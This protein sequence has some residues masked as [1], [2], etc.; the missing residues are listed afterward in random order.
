MQT[1]YTKLFATIVTS[2]IWSESKETK[3]LWVT[4]LALMNKQ[5][6]V[7]ASV[8]GLAK[9]AGLTI[10]E[11]EASLVVLQSPDPYSRS[12]EFE[13]RRV[14][15]IEGGWKMLNGDKYREKLRSQDRAEYNRIKQAEHRAKKKKSQASVRA[16]F[17][18]R[19]RRFVE[20]HNNGDTATADNIAA[21]NL[22]ANE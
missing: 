9:I 8:P 19:E 5:S 17:E 3:I 13:G 11:T 20:A 15:K 4:M 1:G 14:E 16:E 2:T 10:E 18:A 6:V 21:E 22:P 12:S 7:E